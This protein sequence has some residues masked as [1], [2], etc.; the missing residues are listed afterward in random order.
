MMKLSI[1]LKKIVC[2][3]KI[4]L[5]IGEKKNEINLASENLQ[6][7]IYFLEAML[8]SDRLVRKVCVN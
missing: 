3:E 6:P 7:G 2:Q 1:H 5:L 4:D 8:G